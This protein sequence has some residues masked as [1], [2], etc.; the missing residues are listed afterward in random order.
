MLVPGLVNNREVVGVA[1]RSRRAR[2][3]RCSG[4]HWGCSRNPRLRRGRCHPHPH[5]ARHRP[6]PVTPSSTHPR[7]ASAFPCSLK[8]W[9]QRARL[10]VRGEMPTRSEVLKAG[11]QRVQLHA[12]ADSTGLN[13]PREG[14]FHAAQAPARSPWKPRNSG[15]WRHAFLSGGTLLCFGPGSNERQLAHGIQ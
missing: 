5:S 11:L 6:H 12:S 4:C 2:P 15:T 13:A 3:G 7:A 1:A 10:Q 9:R 8:H 14:I